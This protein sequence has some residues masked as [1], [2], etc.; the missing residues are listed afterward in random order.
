MIKQIAIKRLS[1]FLLFAIC[2]LL[3]AV[4]ETYSQIDTSETVS[5]LY[6]IR[7]EEQLE[8]RLKEKISAISQDENVIV[9]VKIRVE[10]EE[11]VV[12]GEKKSEYA[13]PGVPMEK[14]LT[15]KKEE[16][17]EP[18]ILLRER[19][20][21]VFA[22]IFISKEVPKEILEK[23]KEIS[24]QI[25]GIDSERGDVLSIESYFVKNP[26]WQ[27]FK[28]I[29][30]IKSLIS[31]IVLLL[32]VVFLFG[33]L[34]KFFKGL[35]NNLSKKSILLE[36]SP[37]FATSREQTPEK[38]FETKTEKGEKNLFWFI[39]E[40]NTD[41]LAHILSKETSEVI[42]ISLNYLSPVLAGKVFGLL[43]TEKQREL[44]SVSGDL[45]F[46]E[47][48]VVKMV[49]NTI[50]D[51]MDFACGGIKNL[52]HILQASHP[53]TRENIIDWL[54]EK[55]SDFANQ[56]KNYLFEFEDLLNYDDLSFKRILREVGFQSAAMALKECS[57]EILSKFLAKLIPDTADLLTQ[58]IEVLPP[59]VAKSEEEQSKILSIVEK[60]IGDG[61]IPPVKKVES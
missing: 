40:T 31:G 35:V 6:K 43:P 58:Q 49:E 36:Q 32:I 16:M 29:T 33:P 18:E 37:G 13:L 54:K 22:W 45:K 4:P 34:N 26:I 27:N 1:S 52:S 38:K 39:N 14:K 3:L 28:N 25:L 8:N 55:D 46:L 21:N 20:I 41:K 56:L 44:V 50:K 12:Q 47:P 53:T 17:E 59:S 10:K 42:M 11:I 5:E 61:V 24:S 57:K 48:D 7:L 9:V 30:F 23:I 2:C 51:K 19:I 60:L 15:S